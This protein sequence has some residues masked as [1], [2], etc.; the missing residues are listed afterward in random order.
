VA[1]GRNA[2]VVEA[3]KYAILVA[4]TGRRIHYAFLGNIKIHRKNSK[5]GY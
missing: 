5:L 4:E 2:E 3:E 1:A